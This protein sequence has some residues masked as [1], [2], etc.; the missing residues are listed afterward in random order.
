MKIETKRTWAEINL[1]ALKH[2]LEVVKDHT[3]PDAMIMGVVK[4]DAYGHGAI[5]VSKTIINI[6]YF[7]KF[8][9]IY[10]ISFNHI[11]N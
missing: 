11:S 9:F 5:D 7:S 3:A 4:A 1:D 2:N 10:T 6:F 8:F